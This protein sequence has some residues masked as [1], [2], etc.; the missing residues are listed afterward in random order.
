MQA[1]EVLGSS[2][3]C[4]RL[5]QV[6]HQCEVLAAERA[7]LLPEPLVLHDDAPVLE[8]ELQVHNLHGLCPSWPPHS[9]PVYVSIEFQ[10]EKD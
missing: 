9:Q 2:C 3:S 1:E 4:R 7:G 5:G 10:H 6:L 8:V